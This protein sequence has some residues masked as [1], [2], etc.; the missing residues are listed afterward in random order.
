MVSPFSKSSEIKPT[1]SPDH[2]SGTSI[3]INDKKMGCWSKTT[4]G[5]VV[6]HLY[7]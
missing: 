4:A 6:L 1:E 5:G 3:Y 2:E 7:I